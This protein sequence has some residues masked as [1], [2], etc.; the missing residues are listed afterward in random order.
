MS[1]IVV[2]AFSGGL[3][4]SWCVPHLAESLGC[5]VVAVTV[6]TGGLD[7]AAAAELAVRARA[8]GAHDHLLVDGRREYFDSVLRFLIAGN[9]R[10]GG[11][12]P[13]SVGAERSVQARVVA[14]AARELGARA[15]AHGSTAAGND[16][17]RFEVAL[18]AFDPGLEILAPVRDSGIARPDQVAFLAARGLP[19]PPHGAA[20]SVN[21]GLWGTTIGGRETK[22]SDQP[23]PETAWVATRGA[24][25][26]PRA[27]ERHRL[28]FE[29]GIPSAFDGEALD[30]VAL[31]ERV[32]AAA[33]PFGIGR[34]LHL[35]ETVLGIKGRVAYEAPAAETLLTAHRELEKLVLTGRQAK[36]KDLAAALYGDLVHE[37]Q[38]ADPA[39]RDLEALLAS[40]QARVTGEVALL[41]RT[42]ALFVEGVSSPHSLLA[43]S[44]GA[45]GETAGEWSAADARGFSRLVALPAELHARA[46][47]VR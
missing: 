10:R 28:A 8:L 37:G 24:F 31:I 18:R 36:A 9:V 30:P 1:R 20:Y 15:V 11:T 39:A 27:A 6:D 33:A 7:A 13:L 35:G 2:L 4:T 3:D 19:V 41:L 46:G 43:A 42:G 16:Q 38:H 45:Y 32:E 17:V 22:G 29:R 23:L 47:A 40:S 14:R 25:D 34:G 12:Y 26:A 21:R 5:T 44:R